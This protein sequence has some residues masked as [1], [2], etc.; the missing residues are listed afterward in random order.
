GGGPRGRVRGH[1]QQV[2]PRV[3]LAAGARG[4]DGDEGRRG[5]EGSAR[6]LVARAAGRP[7]RR[8]PD[9]GSPLGTGSR[10]RR[11]GGRGRE[12]LDRGRLPRTLVASRG[13]EPLAARGGGGLGRDALRAD[14]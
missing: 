5:G 6:A 10:R 12:G 13:A 7:A 14:V 11:P 3:E 9:T 1:G 2:R 4:L 8:T